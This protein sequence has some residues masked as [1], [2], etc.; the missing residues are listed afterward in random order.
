VRQGA[1]WLADRHRARVVPVLAVILLG[2]C[3]AYARHAARAP[4]GWD[5][6]LQDPVARDGASL[7]LPLWTVTG[8][9]G[10]RRYRISKQVRDLPVAGDTAGLTVGDT[11]SVVARF[12]GTARVAREERREVHRL[13]R[14][15]EALGLLGVV[16]GG[17]LAPMAFRWDR[18]TRRL[19]ER[20]RTW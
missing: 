16:V 7:V 1:G 12:D 6:C 19:E 8:V 18:A 5:W 17:A 15:K 9:D 11:V 13:R 4:H 10:P 3:G 20:W 2:V 14:W